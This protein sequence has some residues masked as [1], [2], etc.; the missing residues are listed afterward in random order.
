MRRHF[1][2][3]LARWGFTALAVFTG[4]T[5]QLGPCLFATA[6]ALYAWRVHRR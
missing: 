2:T 5:H 1:R 4:A 3:P 6:L